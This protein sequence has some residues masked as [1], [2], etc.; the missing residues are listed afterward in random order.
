MTIFKTAAAAALAAVLAT[1]SFAAPLKL[2][3]ADPQP[4]GL[5]QGLEVKYYF[6]SVRSLSEAARAYGKAKPGKPLAGLDYRD[7]AEGDETLTS[8]EAHKVIA[9]IEGY[10]RFDEPGIYKIDFMSNDGL[11]MK[12]GG[13][14]VVYF[15]GVHGCDPSKQ[16]E[17]EVPAAG[18][19]ALEGLYFQRK[20]TACL[21]MRAGIG[22]PKWMEDEAFGY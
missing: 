22:S 5:K 6:D 16:V 21:L 9:V 10:V 1:A 11:E 12:I 20:G 15:D 19:Y 2:K 3:P 7:T 18:W 4:R 13:Q 17:A 14:E 8:G